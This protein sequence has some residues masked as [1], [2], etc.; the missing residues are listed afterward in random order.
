MSILLSAS[1]AGA[2][3]RHQGVKGLWCTT[4]YSQNKCTC[5]SGSARVEHVSGC[6]CHACRALS[7]GPSHLMSNTPLH[8]LPCVQTAPLNW[9]PRP[10]PRGL[11]KPDLHSRA[12]TSSNPTKESLI[13]QSQNHLAAQI[14]VD[15]GPH[16]TINGHRS[17]DTDDTQMP[18]RCVNTPPSAAVSLPF[19]QAMIMLE[20][21]LCSANRSR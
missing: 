15:V 8:P 6:T 19:D 9:P 17:D 4:S 18:A 14:G 16:S 11:C 7:L 12:Y 3:S 13:K 1:S 20:L 2:R 21:Q 5:V 10:P